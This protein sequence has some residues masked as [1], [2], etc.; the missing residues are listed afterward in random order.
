M[1]QS[2]SRLEALQA[3]V[4]CQQPEPDLYRYESQG[5][6]QGFSAAFQHTLLNVYLV[7][8]PCLLHS[9]KPIQLNTKRFK[10]NAKID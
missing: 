6:N 3:V 2:V 5:Q 1:S 4:E 10:L 8:W 7:V 9:L